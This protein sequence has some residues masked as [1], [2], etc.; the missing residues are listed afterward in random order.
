MELAPMVDAFALQDLLV[1][2]VEVG[3]VIL[4]YDI[5]ISP[6]DP[7]TTPAPTSV[8]TAAIVASILGSILATLIICLVIFCIWKRRAKKKSFKLSTNTSNTTTTSTT[9]PV[10]AP[11]LYNLTLSEQ[12]SGS[13]RTESY[14]LYDELP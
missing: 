3:Y 11:A 5:C 10:V 9:A 1:H 4:E 12:Y 2:P 7:V 6:I 13:N 14:H 8:N